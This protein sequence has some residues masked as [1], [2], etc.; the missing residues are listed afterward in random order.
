MQLASFLVGLYADNEYKVS[1]S[2]SVAPIGHTLFVGMHKL[3]IG[4]NRES[5]DIFFTIDLLN[6]LALAIYEAENE[7]N[8]LDADIK[9][10]R[11]FKKGMFIKRSNMEEIIQE[12]IVS[13]CGTFK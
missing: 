4:S 2:I 1:S 6:N 7:Y 5:T 9:T 12:K 3:L 10:K 11:K 8:K 13:Q